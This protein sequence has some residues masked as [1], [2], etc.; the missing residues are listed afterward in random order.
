MVER[1]PAHAAGAATE[2]ELDVQ[3]P[4][5]KSRSAVLYSRSMLYH[6]IDPLQVRE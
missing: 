1:A 5:T 4:I 3:V 2:T 6:I